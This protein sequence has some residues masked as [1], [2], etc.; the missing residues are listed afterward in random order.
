M[1]RADHIR[2]LRQHDRPLLGA[3]DT[4]QVVHAEEVEQPTQLGL[5]DLDDLDSGLRQG[6]HLLPYVGA[7]RLPHHSRPLCITSFLPTW[8]GPDHGR[9]KRSPRSAP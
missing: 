6:V 3:L 9:A 1:R 8:K 7:G 4:D 2:P 5:I